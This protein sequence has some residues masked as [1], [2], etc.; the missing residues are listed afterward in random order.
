M[1]KWV[2]RG[3]FKEPF[4]ALGQFVLALHLGQRPR[5]VGPLDL[6]QRVE[7]LAIFLRVEPLFAARERDDAPG[8][9]QQQSRLEDLPD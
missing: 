6:G 8:A 3:L 7:N 2:V 5:L 1:R 9:A 4:C